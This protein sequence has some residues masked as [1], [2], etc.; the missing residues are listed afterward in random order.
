[1]QSDDAFGTQI[2]NERTGLYS[3]NEVRG[4]DPV[5]LGNARIE[6][7]YF[8]QV[9]RMP[10]LLTDR[11]T[12]R[13]GI[14]AQGFFF[15]APTGLV[16]HQ[17]IG[18]GDQARLSID[19]DSGAHFAPGM[20]V[21]FELPL[22]GSAFGIAGGVGGRSF[23]TADGR[24]NR[25]RNGALLAQWR[26]YAGAEI[27]AF[28]GSIMRTNEEARPTLFVDGAVLPPRIERGVDLSQAWSD[29]DNRT[30]TSGVIARLPVGPIT[31]QGGL[32]R[33]SSADQTRFADLLQGVAANGSV[34]E[35]V[36]I[37]DGDLQTRS[38]SGEV[39]A[40]HEW[41]STA[42]SHR[43]AISLRG[44]DKQR[45][46]GSSRRLSLGSSTV[47]A[48]DPRD[49]PDF[50][51]RPSSHDTVNQYTYGAAYSLASR[52]GVTFGFG[53]SQADYRKQTDFADPLVADAMSSSTP[54][55]W[56]TSASYAVNSWLTVF[57]GAARGLEEAL[58]APESALN[59]AEAPPA[60]LSRQTEGGMRIALADGLSLVAGAF[61]INKP[62]FNLDPGRI[63]R[64]LGTVA[65]TGVELSLSG[66]LAPGLSLV[67]G[68]VLL[69]PVI[70]GEA[71]NAGLI[72]KRPIG[73]PRRRSI[74]NLDWRPEGGSSDWSF[75]VALESLSATTANS[76]NT[77][78]VPSRATVDLGTRYR[79]SVGDVG[80]LLRVRVQN[81][82]N[83]Y[84]W[85]VSSSGGFTYT[86]SRTALIQLI[87]D[88]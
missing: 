34:R 18:V 50:T 25:F 47:L 78:A 66:E 10:R 9:D 14:S 55:L 83:Q 59:R 42:L 37:A 5:D 53:L 46:F 27:K 44:R 31:L 13:V 17:L 71:V 45:N 33:D 63:Y 86:S 73:Q 51:L 61:R 77:L 24:G 75:D 29:R 32:F 40:V 7:L 43:L 38:I 41:R 39:R 85:E 76:A 11:S 3:S 36:I 2:G 8:D 68:T 21:D 20:S 60:I 87:A 70:D 81:L 16:D 48:P 62:Y 65:V 49:E 56:D 88:F 15:P 4:F 30:L 79:F 28:V 1:M 82:L 22:A 80:M 19:A 58:I 72:G 35:R 23:A 54:L 52:G 26:P 67:A 69:D 84:G 6:G 74:L 57:A 12:I 64:Q